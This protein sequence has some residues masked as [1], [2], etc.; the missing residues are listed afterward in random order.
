MKHPLAVVA[1]DAGAANHMLAWLADEADLRPAL[2]GPALALW[3]QARGDGPQ[4]STAEALDGAATLVSGTGWASNHEHDARRMARER[5]IRSIAVIDHWTNYRARFVRDGE[6]VLPDEIWVSDPHARAMAE[7]LFEGVKVVEKP[8]AY[9]A[10][11]LR[12]VLE[13]E[14]AHPAGSRVLYVLEPIRQAWGELP[15]AG[16]FAALD[17]FADHLDLLDLGP[18][19]QVRLRPHPSDAAGKY[20]AWLSRRADPRFALDREPALAAA[21][22]W[23]GVVAGCQTYAMVVAL[24]SGRKVFSTIPPWAPPCILPHPGIIK[25]SDLTKTG[26]S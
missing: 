13:L 20:D 4:M 16:E 15:E 17:F 21:L 10:A 3:R 22:A 14:T 19:T 25:L 6:T 9:L 7:G 8:N 26:H 18:N 12:Q 2:T 1:H 23:S 11:Q 5:G 24:A